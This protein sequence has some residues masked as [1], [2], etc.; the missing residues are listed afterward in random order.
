MGNKGLIKRITAA[1]KVFRGNDLG[2]A[3]KWYEVYPGTKTLSGVRINENSALKISAL[4]AALNFLAST[5]ATLPKIILRRLPGGGREHAFN[6]PLYDR[7]HNKPNDFGLSSWQWIYTS[8]LHKYLWGN[9]YTYLD[10]RNYQNRQFIPLLPQRMEKY[11]EIKELYLYRLKNGQPV[12]F[13][14]SQMLH[15]PHISLDG[16]NGKGIV[17]YA[18]ESLGLAKA[19]EEFAETFFGSGIHAGGFVEIDRKVEEQDRKELQKDFNEMYGGLGRSWKA[20]LLTGGAKW[21]PEDIDATKAQAL[22]SRQFSVVEIARWMNLPPHIL[23][24]LIRATFSNI[25]E[26]SLELVIYSLLPLA[27]QI[28][29]AM[30]IALF[31]DT[32]RRT[33]YVKFE[34]K[35]LL[36]GDLKTRTEFYKAM[37]DRGVFNADMVLELEDMN[38]QPNNLGQVYVLPLNMLNK[39]TIV[40]GQP[41]LIESK[42]ASHAEKRA[43]QARGAALRRR[44]TIAYKPK[45]EQ[46]AKQLVKKEVGAVRKAIK[47]MLAEHGIAD[48]SLWLND[49]YREF[50]KE[51]DRVISPTI[52]SY[53][54]AILPMAQEEAGNEDD[55][56]L[57]YSDFQ[58]KYREAFAK[59]HIVSS[60]EQLKSVMRK[61]QDEGTSELEALE[62]RLDEWEEKR[63][64]KIVMR[65]AV[66]TENA[67]T[68]SVFA[69]CGVMKI[70]SVSYDKSCPYCE[71]LD[72]KVIGIDDNFLTS[73]E[74][75]PDG[76]DRPLTVPYNHKHPPYHPGCDC[77]IVIA[78]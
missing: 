41:L 38:P 20:I 9:W 46:Y 69:L 42:N 8:I 72:G 54:T 21:K 49:F 1:I 53:A 71:A 32:E 78:A 37:L 23:R 3:D 31:D 22:E 62:Q 76:A 16:I 18:R 19:Q 5:M 73:G 24:D 2:Y 64:G 75:Q 57:Q 33:H 47:E 44:L 77:G 4:F 40:S 17:H 6:H 30:N 56:G 34:L 55:I 52:S 29:Q 25:E 60:H 58:R 28:E 70:M 35:G 27:T 7:L 43:L 15:I 59:R 12:Y 48:F 50:P 68:R 45:F 26:Q 13:S 14:K 61:A 10:R 65:E 11:D 36:R 39:E 74:F 63:P 66:Q 51:I 67:F